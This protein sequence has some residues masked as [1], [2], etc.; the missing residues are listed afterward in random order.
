MGHEDNRSRT[1]HAFADRQ[2]AGEMRR[3]R[4]GRQLRNELASVRVA[5]ELAPV[6][7]H[8]YSVLCDGMGVDSAASLSPSLLTTVNTIVFSV[9]AHAEGADP[10]RDLA[11]LLIAHNVE[12]QHALVVADSLSWA[13]SSA[14]L[15]CRDPHVTPSS[16]TEALQARQRAL[17]TRRRLRPVRPLV[18]TPY[19]LPAA[20]RSEAARADMMWERRLQREAE[21]EEEGGGRGGGWGWGGWGGEGGSLCSPGSGGGSLCSPDASLALASL[22]LPSLVTYQ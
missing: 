15:A 3:R 18:S 11:S 2:A 7:D 13:T 21:A 6:I 8:A 9:R 12:P 20:G 14:S 16:P 19:P 17:S 5:S 4:R 1:A 10:R 22:P